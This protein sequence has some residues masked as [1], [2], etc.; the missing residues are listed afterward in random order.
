[1]IYQLAIVD[2][3]HPQ[4]YNNHHHPSHCHHHRGITLVGTLPP[5]SLPLSP[6]PKSPPNWANQIVSY[7]SGQFPLVWARLHQCTFWAR[8][9]LEVSKI[10]D[11]IAH[12]VIHFQ[13]RMIFLC[14][15]CILIICK[16]Y[17]KQFFRF[18]GYIVGWWLEFLHARQS[19]E[20]QTRIK[21]SNAFGLS[22]PGCSLLFNF[23][24]S[25]LFHPF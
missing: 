22:P 1:M 12:F 8:Q 17:L 5:V 2:Q 3:N 19:A 7:N 14:S 24:L 23:A 18:G 6:F 16:H 11:T 4:G 13:E 25:I 9:I 10:F 21:M 20:F 15:N